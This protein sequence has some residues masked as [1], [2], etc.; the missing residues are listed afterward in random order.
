MK[1]GFI[2]LGNMAKAMISGILKE[3]IVDKSDIIGSAHTKETCEKVKGE[4]GIAT[5]T[6]NA[7]VASNV[8]VL[9]LAVKPQMFPEAVVPLKDVIKKDTLIVSIAAGKSIADL[10]DMLGKD[11]R[12]VRLMPNTPAMVG[13]G[14][15]SVTPSENATEEDI[16]IVK[17]ICD[18]FGSSEVIPERLVDAF[19]AVA[20]SSPAYVFMFIEA[21]A[22]AGV[23]AGLPR[24]KAYKFAAT[25]TMGSAKLMLDT[26]KHPGELKDMVC[27]PGGTTIEAV[28]VLEEM[29]LRAAVMD[30]VEACVEKTKRL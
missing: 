1:I 9:I 19:C 22:D 15:T 20:G 13:A 29:G 4:Y 12:I 2:G 23:K 5:T 8:D 17:K 11:K 30:A 26:G 16:A 3:G 28:Q 27:S 24:D 25:S 21:M 10:E 18:S 7:E 14:V 6:L